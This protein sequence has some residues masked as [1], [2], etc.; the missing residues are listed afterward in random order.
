MIKHLRL[1][2]FDGQP[3]TGNGGT[4]RLI[5]PKDGSVLHGVAVHIEAT[6]GTNPVDGRLCLTSMEL[7]VDGRQKYFTTPGQETFINELYDIAGDAVMNDNVA[8][9]LANPLALKSSPWGGANVGKIQL[10]LNVPADS[11]GVSEY[12]YAVG[13]YK[14]EPVNGNAPLGD[15]LRSIEINETPL[16]TSNWNEINNP[17]VDDIHTLLCLDL[18]SSQVSEAEVYLGTEL[19]WEGDRDR[20]QQL[21][22]EDPAL[23]VPADIANHFVIVFDAYGRFDKALGLS[24]QLRV[25]YKASGTTAFSTW[26]RGIEKTGK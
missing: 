17:P 18:A 5:I 3:T 2:D 23:N 20:M 7:L 15:I 22:V 21:L 24:A 25:K 16:T 12:G 6:D 11:A 13:Y 19:I 4:P 10:K 1:P 14:S 8:I 26:Y 9:Q